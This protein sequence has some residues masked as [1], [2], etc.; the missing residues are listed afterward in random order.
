MITIT[1]AI[2]LCKRYIVN[3]NPRFIYV[4]KVR[5]SKFKSFILDI[6]VLFLA[7]ATR[8]KHLTAT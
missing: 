3:R 7:C 6:D 2:I 1:T 5:C 4:S 8:I